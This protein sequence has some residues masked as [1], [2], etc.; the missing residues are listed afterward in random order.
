MATRFPGLGAF[1]GSLEAAWEL[2]RVRLDN[3]LRG[4]LNCTGS[5]TL[6][7]GATSTTLTDTRIGG[8]SVILFCPTTSTA[9]A[10][11]T[12]LRVTA[13]GD[14]TATLTHNNTA[15]VDRTLDY[16]IIG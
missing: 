4:K 13:K 7:A 1:P 16:A 2:L 3:L 5:V 12:A 15:D 10:A 6:T 8:S 14:G 9:A 11:M